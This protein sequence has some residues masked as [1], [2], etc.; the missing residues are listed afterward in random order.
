MLC[1]FGEG[2]VRARVVQKTFHEEEKNFSCAI[3]KNAYYLIEK[4]SLED[5]SVDIARNKFEARMG[6]D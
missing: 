2:R 5:L 6:K 3:E 4:V 1:D